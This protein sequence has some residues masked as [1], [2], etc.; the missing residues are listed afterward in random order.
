M[1]DLWRKGQRAGGTLLKEPL[2]VVVEDGQ[3]HIVKGHRRALAL[4]SLQGMW[5][6][7][8][9]WVRCLLFA[10]DDPRVAS[11]YAK[12]DTQS[13]GLSLQLH[14]LDTKSW[15]MDKP[16][17]PTANDKTC[18]KEDVK[19]R[20]CHEVDGV[21]CEQGTFGPCSSGLSPSQAP[22]RAKTMYEHELL[23]D[24][25][26]NSMQKLHV[27]MLVYFKSCRHSGYG[28]V[29]EI[30]DSKVKLSYKGIHSCQKLQDDW[31]SLEKLCIPDYSSL[32]PGME[33]SVMSGK[34]AYSCE[35]AQVSTSKERLR[36]PVLVRFNSSNHDEWVGMDRL[37]T[38]HVKLLPL[39]VDGLG[40]CQ[41]TE[42]T[43]IQNAATAPSE[44]LTA[45][46]PADISGDLYESKFV[47]C[48]WLAGKC[49]QQG[50]HVLG[51]TLYLH[52][53]VDL[54]CGFGAE[55]LYKHFR[56]RSHS[57]HSGSRGPIGDGTET[58]PDSQM[59]SMQKLHVSML[60]YFKSCRHSGFGE[61]LEISDSKVKLSYKGIHSCQKRQDDWVSLDKLHIPDY[62]SLQPG[63]EVSVMSG[64]KAYSCEVAQVSTSKERLRAPVLVRFNSSNHDE[65]VGMDRLK[66]KHVKLLPLKVDGLG[67]CQQTEETSIQNAATAPSEPLTAHLPADI[68]GDLYESKFVCCLWLAGKCK[69]QGPHV[70]GKTLY[71]HEDVDLP[72]G[73]EAEC[74]YKHF[75]SRS[76]SGHSGSRGPIGD[77][78]ETLPDSQMNSMQKLHVS[79]L[80]YF[81]SCRHSGFGEVLEIS[82]SKVK[83][84]YKS[85]HSCQ[86]RQDD[87]V[88]LEK[89][90][91][92]D[93]SSLQPG[94]EVSVM[95]G[96][97]AY[98][99][100]V[101][102]VSTSKERLRAPALVRFNSHNHDEW[103]GMDRLKTKY[104]KLL[105]WKVDGLG[106]C[107]QTE[108]TSIQNASTA[109]CEPLTAH[110][111]ADISGDLYES[112]FVC[113][114]WLAGKCKQQGPH[115]L[116]KTL[117]LHEDVDL[118]CGFGAECLY[119]HFRSRSHSGFR[120][121]IGDG[122]ETL[123]DSQMNSMQKL[124]V[125]MLVYF[126]SC[127]HSGFGEVLE[128]S[129]SKVK[130]SYKS[131]HSCQKR[132]D[133]W[134]SLDKLYIPDYSSLQPG[135]EV[136]VQF[137][138]I[139][140]PCRVLEVLPSRERQR[141]PLHISYNFHS[142]EQDEWIGMDQLPSHLKLLPFKAFAAISPKP[143]LELQ[144]S[145][146]VHVTSCGNP[147]FGEV[148]EVSGSQ[149]K[150]SY[151]GI[152]SCQKHEDDWVPV[153]HLKVPD[154]SSLQPGME[155]SVMSGKKAYSCVV[156]QVST[157]KERLR[158]PVLVRF[159]SSN[160][161]EWVGIDRLKTKHVKLL[162]LKVDG[163]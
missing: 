61:V 9:V 161:D 69:Q 111:P 5:R 134:V 25:Q 76:H 10:A 53:D 125:S 130:L 107:Q 139:T 51:K 15:H 31:V 39:K 28:E 6:D 80:V 157:S 154:Y 148:L 97:K 140:L 103:V 100:E 138:E 73:F 144:P 124:H 153:E 122:T 112:K 30:S 59:N 78:T 126:K 49:K 129:D 79:M 114:L 56:S 132:Q 110:L 50:P 7:R 63:M 17:F 54:P 143:T 77:G 146:L 149:V 162:R 159:N 66:T 72:C 151:R 141:K 41:Q 35:V 93:Y 91:I 86:K 58:L 60:V 92:P 87:W 21:S 37:K 11:Q 121:P 13:R 52:E 67:A 88:S 81:K 118:P 2:H 26:M 163:L 14:G 29:L 145:M 158:A 45:H 68:S 152:H 106:A 27:S 133:D 46:L 48:L 36:A 47:C 89:L 147:H 23:P 22:D 115:V 34:K 3:M 108:E 57:G 128:I 62:S 1:D 70:L 8:T 135:I 120:G 24:S 12:R 40:A 119:K 98:S 42:E 18:D 85:I 55:C 4:S 94:M 102:Q 155:V 90:C 95:S 16:L 142:Q 150:L 82:D 33:V 127:R 131:I 113:C 83:L 160:H 104:V 105:P 32:Q 96:K 43:S 65:W 64:K 38:K 75:R 19:G 101:A 116:G 117:Y 109:P 20:R 44:P 137:G 71:L 156:S 123:P 84:S 136:S 74:L 99:C